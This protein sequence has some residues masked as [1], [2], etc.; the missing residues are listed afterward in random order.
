M[1]TPSKLNGLKR[2]RLLIGLVLI[3]GLLL[4]AIPA[5][6]I[7]GSDD[8]DDPGD[9][10]YVGA[11]WL[12]LNCCDDDGNPFENPIPPDLPP[13]ENR[14]RT[15]G[16]L[17]A[18][19]VFLTQGAAYRNGRRVAVSLNNPIADADF[20]DPDTSFEGYVF[21]FPGLDRDA[22][23]EPRPFDLAVIVLDESVPWFDA[24]DS[25]RLAPI[26][27]L[28]ALKK[29]KSKNPFTALSYG[30]PNHDPSTWDFVRRVSEWRLNSLKAD[31][32]HFQGPGYF[33]CDGDQG[34][35]FYSSAGEVTALLIPSAGYCSGNSVATGYRLDTQDVRDFLCNVGTKGYL[36]D[37][38]VPNPNFPLLGP[39]GAL[40]YSEIADPEVLTDQYCDGNSSSLRAASADDGGGQSADRQQ[41]G[42]NNDKSKH[43]KGKHRGKGKRGR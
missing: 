15:T 39:E 17:I 12:V 38:E 22:R 10:P 31:T 14:V 27:T 25:P 8:L 18:P 28:E 6:A 5:R 2:S 41:N 9:Y 26:G 21:H 34:A 32:A 35:P 4:P 43:K 29:S 42:K 7:V 23:Q 19:N 20:T 16:I 37:Q 30:P 36:D 11:A 3:V 1:V 24:D 13:G 40:N 33:V